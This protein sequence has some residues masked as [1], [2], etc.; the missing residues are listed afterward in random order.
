MGS[1]KNPLKQVLGQMC[2]QSNCTSTPIVKILKYSCTPA[3][4]EL[5]FLSPSPPNTPLFKCSPSSQ[6]WSLPQRAAPG[7][8][9][10]LDSTG[11]E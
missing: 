2:S 7:L 11:T 6:R 4:K 3:G 9:S 8:C 5:I 1:S 10:R